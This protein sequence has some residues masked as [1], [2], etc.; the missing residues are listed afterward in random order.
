MTDA[1]GP[2]LKPASTAWTGTLG[3]D[4]AAADLP[5][6]LQPEVSA[7][8]QITGEWQGFLVLCVTQTLARHAAAAMFGMPP[9]ELEAEMVRDA[10]GEMANVLGGAVKAGIPGAKG[11]SLPTVVQGDGHS[12]FVPDMTVACVSKL[13]C[14]GEPM[15]VRLY[16]HTGNATRLDATSHST[17]EAA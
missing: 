2:W 11:L 1:Q 9:E 17:E 7:F 6:E 12:V 4:V 10:M 8:V 14:Q 15:W 5:P 13:R 3:L 16:E